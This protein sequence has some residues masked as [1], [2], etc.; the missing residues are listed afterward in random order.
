LLVGVSPSHSSADV[1]R[2]THRLADELKCEWFA[3]YVESLRRQPLKTSDQLQLDKNL[4]LAQELGAHIARLSGSDAA[5]EIIAFANAKNVSL[6]VIGFS[7]RSKVEEIFKGSIIS[8]IVQKSDPIQVLVVPGSHEHPEPPP[9]PKVKTGRFN[10]ANLWMSVASIVFTTAISLL[11]RKVLNVHDIV[12]L[13]VI[14]IVLTGV[15]AGLTGGILASV[16]AVACFNFFFIPPYY[17][18]A[19]NDLR[20]LLTFAILMFSGVIVSILANIVRRQSENARRREKFIQTLYE[21]SRKLLSTGNRAAL[22]QNIA[23]SVSE[24]FETETVLL[25]PRDGKI[26]II[27]KSDPE[28]DFSERETGIAQWVFQNKKRAGFGT[29]TLVSSRWQFNPLTFQDRMLGI[30]AIKPYNPQAMQTFEKQQ[31]LESFLN[32][33]ALSLKDFD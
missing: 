7:K 33:V 17:T 2:T 3:V 26:T 28:C 23:Q 25:L 8:D 29:G 15:T 1:I 24:L 11:L 27:Y 19:I 5:K 31:L 20:F 32:I 22:Y 4:T 13:Y 6:I 14:P 10:L 16:F 30:L 12:L 9:Q 18:F 21:F